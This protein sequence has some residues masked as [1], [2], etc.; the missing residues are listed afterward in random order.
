MHFTCHCQCNTTGWSDQNLV[1]KEVV[2]R[3]EWG[4]ELYGIGWTTLKPGVRV[5]KESQL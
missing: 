4:K 3:A 5:C 1:R 2:L